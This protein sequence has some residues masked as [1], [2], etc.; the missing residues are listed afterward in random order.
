MVTVL[1]TYLLLA[2]LWNPLGVFLLVILRID[3]TA[4]VW[5][6]AIDA[7]IGVTAMMLLFT[8]FG[9]RKVTAP[10]SADLW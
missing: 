9:V 3:S 10:A 4:R 2:S 8:R 5:F 7:A 1:I 6:F